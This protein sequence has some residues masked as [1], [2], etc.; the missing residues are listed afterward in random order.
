MKAQFHKNLFLVIPIDMVISLGKIQLESA[1]IV[2]VC[3][4]L[5]NGT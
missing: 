4:A 5:L 1:E 2:L 3:V